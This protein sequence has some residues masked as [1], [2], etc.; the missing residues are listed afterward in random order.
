MQSNY[1]IPEV[2]LGPFQTLLMESFVKKGNGYVLFEG[3]KWEHC[4]EIG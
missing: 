4:P 3:I 2:Y 1:C